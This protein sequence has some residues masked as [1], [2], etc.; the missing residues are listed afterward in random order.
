MAILTKVTA[1]VGSKGHRPRIRA[2]YSTPVISTIGIE[3]LP[4][5]KDMN[6]CGAS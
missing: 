5:E 4:T 2:V 6:A 3:N 1:A